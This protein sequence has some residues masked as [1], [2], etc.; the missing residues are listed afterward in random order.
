MGV[1]VLLQTV[2]VS[3]YYLFEESRDHW[4]CERPA[5]RPLS[6]WTLVLMGCVWWLDPI[7]ASRWSLR[8]RIPAFSF[9]L[10]CGSFPWSVSSI[11]PTSGRF[12]YTLIPVC[13]DCESKHEP[14]IWRRSFSRGLLLIIR[15]MGLLII[16][17]TILLLIIHSTILPHTQLQASSKNQAKKAAPFPT[18]KAAVGRPSDRT[19]FT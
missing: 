16:H 12:F 19:K 5:F 4:Y 3:R 2:I 18:D 17:S 9:L 8:L 6:L 10:P 15:S 13:C 7:L 1:A 14:S 11:V